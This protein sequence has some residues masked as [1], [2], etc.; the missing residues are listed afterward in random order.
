MNNSEKS[1]EEKSDKLSQKKVWEDP[2][3]LLLSTEK[4]E[5]ECMV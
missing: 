2:E 3:L 1:F 4:T 5:F